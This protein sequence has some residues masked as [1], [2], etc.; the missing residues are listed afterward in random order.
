MGTTQII[1]WG[2]IY[3]LFALLI[4]PLERELGASRMAVA[5]AF[6]VSL[7]VSGLAAP[8]IGRVIDRVGGR[9]VMTLGSMGGA[10]FLALLSQV[11]S[12]DMLYLAWAG[13]GL[14]MAATLYDAAFAVVTHAYQGG[15]RRAITALT[16]FGGF[17]STVFWPLTTWLTEMLGWRQATLC[18]AAVNLLICVPIHFWFVPSAHGSQDATPAQQGNVWE[19]LRNP[20]FL[21]FA[22]S[23][24]GQ[25]LAI[26]ALGAHFLTLLAERGLS[27]GEAAAVGA[28]IGPM[29][30]AGR[31]LEMTFSGRISAVQVGRW[32]VWLLPAGLV[33]LLFAG[34]QWLWLVLFV[35]FY[36]VGN[37]AMTIVRGAAPAELF[38]REQY[39]AM[40]G[41]MAG[42]A[43]VAR[44]GGPFLASLIWAWGGYAAVLLV[45]G[46]VSV[47]AAGLYHWSTRHAVRETKKLG[48]EPEPSR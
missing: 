40:T 33:V 2:S 28:L 38:G 23:F 32:A 5:G 24:V 21:A 4:G 7:L 6:S 9:E 22:V 41:A 34:G 35:A 14:A 48:T 47:L 11:H 19:W 37:G 44:A 25:S 1:A 43:M 29:Q 18:L 26:S 17:A 3:Y 46:L 13:L 45:L 36:G 16:V 10:L 39:G 12:L 27:A 42:P 15:Y 8:W 31:V 20:A 30:V